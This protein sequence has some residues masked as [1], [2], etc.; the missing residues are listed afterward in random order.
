ME[1]LLG[2]VFEIVIELFVHLFAGIASS[3]IS[4]FVTRVEDDPKF[5]NRIKMIVSFVFF[6]LSILL[7]ILALVYKKTFLATFTLSYLFTLII[8]NL[9]KFINKNI[10]KKGFVDIIISWIRRIAHY[11]F[12]ITLII[13]GPSFLTS[14][15][16]DV[17]LIVLSVIAIIVYLVIDIYKVHRFFE[18]RRAYK[19]YDY[20]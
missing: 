3:I 16:A 1:E 4:S 11:G 19:Y 2:I 12:P 7:L 10:L 8:L 15:A 18:K 13:I 5:K 6:G 20:N 9:F 14:K 17:W